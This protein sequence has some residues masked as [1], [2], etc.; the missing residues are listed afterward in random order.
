MKNIRLILFALIALAYLTAKAIGHKTLVYITKPLLMPAL[1]LWLAYETRARESRFLRWAILGGLMFA[2]IGDILLLST[3]K[4]SGAFFFLLGLGAFL[5]THL[6]YI[7]GFWSVAGREKGYLFKYP[8]WAL[9]FVV[10][11]ACL[12]WWLWPGIPV[13]MKLPVTVY[14]IV[15]SA[16]VMSIVHLKGRIP[17]A[18]FRNMLAGGLLF[19]LSDSLIAMHKFGQD[20]SGSGFLVMITYIL[21]QFLIVKSVRDILVA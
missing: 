6:F 4:T 2:T 14:A 18:A 3:G 20:F 17:A 8:L 12:L 10:F 15:I 5:F 21:G 7:G 13:G 9:P 19:M 11:T 16:M 1:A